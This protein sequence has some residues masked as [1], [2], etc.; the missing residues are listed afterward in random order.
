MYGVNNTAMQMNANA[1]LRFGHPGMIGMNSA[2]YPQHCMG[3]HSGLGGCGQYA[4]HMG[5][6][7]M[8]PYMSMMPSTSLGMGMHGI[9]PQQI[10]GAG[11]AGAG[12]PMAMGNYGAYGSSSMSMGAYGAYAGSPMIGGMRM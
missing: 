4:G 11:F 8:S 12:I 7:Q 3:T 9:M 5:M 10:M 2:M 6:R 1:A